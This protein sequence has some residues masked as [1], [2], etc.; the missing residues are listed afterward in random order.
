METWIAQHFL[1]PAFVVGGTALVASPIIIHLINRMRFKRVRF[2]AM[3]FLLQ[4]S[5]RNRRR[6]LIE[7]L[8]LLLLRVLIVLAIVA[9][10]SRLVLDPS[11]MSLFQGAQAHH[12]VLLDDSGSMRDQSGESTA[13]QQAVEIVKKLVAEGSRRPGTQKFT[14]VAMSQPDQPLFTQREVDDQFQ[15]ELD[16]KLKNL[17]C[18]HQKLSLSAG[19]DGARNVLIEDR[20][21]IRHLHVISDFREG[22]WEDQ[23]SL[24]RTVQEL[25]SAG[26]T[27]NFV[28]TVERRNQNLGITSLTG[29]VQVASARVPVRL[30]VGV[31]NFGDQVA[32]N[33]SVGVLQDGQ[34]LPLTINFDKIEA[35]IE[36][37]QEF[38]LTFES[39]GRHRVDLLLP[40]DPL[41]ADNSRFLSVAVSPINRVLIIE[42]NPTSDDG[43]YL[44][45]AL[46]ADPGI[47]G[48]S[49]QLETPD[50]LRRRPLDEF[51]SIYLL[52]VGELPADALAPLEDYVRG[53]GGLVWFLGNEIRPRFYI[54]ELY[55]DGEGL[56]PVKLGIVSTLT[57][58]AASEGGPDTVFEDHPAFGVFQG[59]ENPFTELIR[60][61]EYFPVDESWEQ[62]D[63]RRGDD[64]RTIARLT[65]R[66]PLMFEERFG[67]GT[68]IAC[69]TSCGPLWNNWARYPSY[70]A[71][72]LD[73]EKYVARKD[74]VLERRVVGEPIELSLDPAEF[75]D[76]VEI[77]GPDATGNRV[78]RLKAAPPR[79]KSTDGTSTDGTSTPESSEAGPGADSP[80]APANIRLTASYRDT[81]TPGIY[82]VRILDQSQSPVEKWITFNVPTDESRLALA[83]TELI[84]KQIGN[85]LEV[86]IQEPGEFSWIA[87]RDAG[88]EV[89]FWLLAGLVIFMLAEQLLGYRLSFHARPA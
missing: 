80:N 85:N 2:A 13:F 29:D 79:A 49:P 32:S 9:I 53:G 43:D 14:L 62:D 65:N 26:V 57:N 64:V 10:V 78:T 55:R 24:A 58:A 1:N 76:E 67:E 74:R 75:L 77:V 41:T 25:D 71:M 5:R 59:Q 72:M 42:G 15:I 50:Y 86:R 66:S 87:G 45:D 21:A 20:A 16:T 34:K 17:T 8:L 47:T 31:Q 63:Q 30:S 52:N 61:Y 56:F 82:Q 88:Q 70:V 81:D 68:V 38:D 54:T 3:E 7:Q 73:L 27:I 89:R 44:V 28:K 46:A 60:V 39:A 12:V 36:V 84:R 22:D 23:Q 4:S 35:G 18:S 11:E 33:V 37:Q 6:V 19:F 69:L 40:V 48:Y 83:P 51:Q